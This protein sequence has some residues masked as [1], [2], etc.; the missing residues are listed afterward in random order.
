MV[1]ITWTPFA[2]DFQP[3]PTSARPEPTMVFYIG[4][5]NL[6]HDVEMILLVWMCLV[7][8]V[9]VVASSDFSE[10]ASSAARAHSGLT[11]YLGAFFLGSDPFVYFYLSNGNN[12]VSYKALNSGRPV[13]RPTKG[14]G[15]VRDPALVQ[16]GGEEAGKKWYIVGTD[17]DI[18]KVC[19][20]LCC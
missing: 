9:T 3:F 7:A 4:A 2:P 11:G 15:G 16:G 6:L 12:P 5:R 17:L 14:T 1:I 18:A 10:G 19:K 8:S 20:L 13:I